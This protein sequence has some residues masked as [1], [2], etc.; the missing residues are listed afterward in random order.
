MVVVPR[1]LMI[2]GQ[3]KQE[4]GQGGEQLEKT[5]GKDRLWYCF[6]QQL[7]KTVSKEIL[8]YCFTQE[9]AIWLYLVLPKTF[10]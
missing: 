2:S 5:V 3:Q 1:E 7:G 8:W 6:T 9:Q 10:Q 4:E